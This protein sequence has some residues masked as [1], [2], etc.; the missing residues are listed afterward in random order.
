ML[1]GELLAA[2]RMLSGQIVTE[3]QSGFVAMVA[4]GDVHRL[5][6][7]R[8]GDLVN[9][10]NVGD[11]PNAVNDAEVVGGHERRLPRNRRFENALSA[12]FPIRIQTKDLAEVGAAGF[13]ELKPVGFGAAM[14]LFVRMDIAFPEPLQP[15]SAHKSTASEPLAALLE[16]LVVNVN[17]R[18]GLGEEDSLADPIA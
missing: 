13:P 17:G 3:V 9:D 7:H 16:L 6:G 15:R 14:R 5:A 8:H 10:A 12:V 18:V 2:L 1:G 4:V 11:G